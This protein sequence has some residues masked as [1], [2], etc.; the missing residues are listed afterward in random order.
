MTIGDDVLVPV[1]V[2]VGNGGSPG[3]VRPQSDREFP[4]RREP[5]MF[6]VQIDGVV[7]AVTVTVRG[8]ERC[9]SL[10]YGRGHEQY[11]AYVGHHG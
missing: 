7:D 6:C 10:Q 2:E 1:A 3:V 4:R 8:K 11:P 9:G 5:D